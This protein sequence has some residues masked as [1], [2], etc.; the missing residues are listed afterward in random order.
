[1]TDRI[2]GIKDRDYY[3][4][5]LTQFNTNKSREYFEKLTD[6]ELIDNYERLMRL[7]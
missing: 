1:M 2:Q 4:E 5:I 7:D 3:I 6:R